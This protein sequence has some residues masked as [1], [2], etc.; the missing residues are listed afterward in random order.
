MLGTNGPRKM[1]VAVP[2]VNEGVPSPLSAFTLLP[3]RLTTAPLCWV[4]RGR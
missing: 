3:Y 4:Q 2:M 1:R